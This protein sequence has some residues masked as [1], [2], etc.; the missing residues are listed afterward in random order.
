MAAIAQRKSIDSLETATAS[1]MNAG[2]KNVMTRVQRTGA[3]LV[4]N[5]NRPE[6]VILSVNEYDELIA[7]SAERKLSDD[8]ALAT[9]RKQFD[10]RLSV[11]HSKGTSD[12]LRQLATRPVKLRGKVKTGPGR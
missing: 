5:H 8:A 12:K 11:L 3:V 7:A 2:W 1:E 6:A 4:K 10:E 9:L